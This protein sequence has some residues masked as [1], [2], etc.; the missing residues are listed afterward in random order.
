MDDQEQRRN[1]SVNQFLSN[2][3]EPMMRTAILTLGTTVLL[4]SASVGLAQASGQDAAVSEAV[5]RQANRITLRQKISDARVAQGRNDLA[6]SARL[7]DESWEIVQRIGAGVDQETAQVRTGLG[8]VRMELAR[9]AQRRG[10]L[11]AAKVHVDDV[12]RVDPQNTE[13]R[14]FAA[15]NAK[16]AIEQRGLTPSED[17]QAQMPK[18]AEEKAKN[19]TLVQDGRLFLEAGK[20]VEAEAKLRQAVKEDPQNQAAYYYL[21]LVREAR[22]AEA[23]SK[24]DTS[25]RQRLV[26]V[27]EAWYTPP[28]R[29]K[30]PVPNPYARTNLIHTSKGRQAIAAKL[31][32][33]RLDSVRYDGLPL[34]E[35]IVNL[36]DE[37]RKRDPEKR[38]LNFIIN[39]NAEAPAA[40]PMIPGSVDPA[41]GLPIPAMAAPAEQVDVAAVGIKINPPLTD[42]RLAEVLDAIIKVADKPIK[43]SI[44]D[45]AVVFSLK[46]QEAA[47]LYTRLI[48]VDPNTFLQGLESVVSYAFGDISTSSGGG[49]GGG[50]GGSRGGGGGGSQGGQGG[51]SGGSMVPRVNVAAGGGGGG[52]GRGGG[53]GGGGFG[54][55][56]GGGGGG[57]VRMVTSTNN[58]EGVH[59]MVRQFFMT[60]GIDLNP[61]KSIFFN[62]REGTLVV[63]ATLQDLDIIEGAVQVLNIAPPQINI[64]TKF[65]EVT[66]NDSRALGFDW[67][68]GN[69]TMGGG[70]VIT[71]GGTAPSY[72]GAAS[73]ANPQGFFPGTSPLYAIPS[74]GSDQLVTSGLRNVANAPAV[75]SITGI[76]T[77]PQFRVVI[78]ALEQREGV[79]LLNE[80]S[81]TTLSGRQTQIQVVDMITI[82]T[83]TSLDQNTT[84]GGGGTTG[85]I[86]GDTGGG[87]VGSTINYPTEVLPFGPTLDVIPY[88]S[89]DGYTIQMTIIPT[90]TEFLGYDDPGQF[91]PQ[92]QSVSGG[93]GGAAIPLRAQLPLPHFRLRQV[94]TSAIVWDGQTVVLGGLITE[95]VQKLKDKV[96]VLGDLP[97]LGRLFRSESSSTKKKNLMIFVTPTI[98]D[99]A[100][101]RQNSEDEMPF[102]QNAI[103]EQKPFVP[104]GK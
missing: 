88:V 62:D 32:K 85:G 81:V 65:V 61:P 23:L 1:L 6:T 18:L 50:G 43:Y 84:G 24:R 35:V 42:V 56:G 102:A 26:E 8:Q 37:A 36:N 71:A 69:V 2:R 87:A 14:A 40:Q 44:E 96:P 41:T 83:G 86:G 47:P 104:V 79:D 60:M 7:Y 3:T 93:S 66:Q 15:E 52:G 12:L 95:D 11:P 89:A 100:G 17:A 70:K 25:S 39:P 82:V 30:L 54:G 20:L 33:I 64:K 99:P 76:L 68:L 16:L 4:A 13:A 101:N 45:Y 9:A 90:I 77:D 103:P 46:G 94:T 38:G 10:D 22:Y 5:Y 91:V 48:K 74:S 31:D 98:I 27:E 72:N 92:A 34:G 53:G 63:R 49:G 58:M 97:L 80:A 55:G 75:A 19:N 73:T 28:N 59:A 67:Y 21:N 29:E 78:R 57:G 51:G